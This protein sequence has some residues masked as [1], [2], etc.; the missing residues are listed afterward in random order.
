[1]PDPTPMLDGSPIEK[2]DGD[3]GTN[4]EIQYPVPWADRHSFTP[5]EMTGYVVSAKETTGR[6]RVGG[7]VVGDMMLATYEQAIIACTYSPLA[8]GGG[9]GGGINPEWTF[10]KSWS[11]EIIQVGPLYGKKESASSPDIILEEGAPIL[12]PK[13]EWTVTHLQTAPSGPGYPKTAIAAARGHI[14]N[15]VFQGVPLGWVLFHGV[16]T[17][18]TAAYDKTKIDI[19]YRF[20]EGPRDFRMR[21]FASKGEWLYVYNGSASD[22]EKASLDPPGPGKSIYDTA[23]FGA[24]GVPTLP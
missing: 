5:P 8:P 9:G 13:C 7:E 2:W 11:D 12:V 22:V 19:T 18:G 14:N 24:L 23:D 20:T 16:A 17:R 3:N 6:G 15:A 1:M 4:F 21:F 10:D